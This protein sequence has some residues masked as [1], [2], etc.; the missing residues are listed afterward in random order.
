[1]T[2]SAPTLATAVTADAEWTL[3]CHETNADSCTALMSCFSDSSFADPNATQTMDEFFEFNQNMTAEYAD[4]ASGGGIGSSCNSDCDC[5]Y[6]NFCETT[7]SS[8]VCRYGG[9][10]PYGC[11]RG[12]C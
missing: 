6:C 8:G 1:M 10:G 7:S 11:Y 2:C 4:G 12:F 9:E 5:G 3:R